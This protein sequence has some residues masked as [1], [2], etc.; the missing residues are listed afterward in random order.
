[1]ITPIEIGLLIFSYLLG[2]VPVGYLLTL[3]TTGKNI[4]ELGSGNVGSTNVGRVAGKKMA[5]LTQLLDMAKG[6]IPVA[7]VLYLKNKQI[8]MDD[9]YFVFG[10]ALAA[11]VGHNFSIFLSGKGGKGVNTTLGASLLIAPYAVFISVGIYFLV[12]WKT[13]YVSIGSLFLALSLPLS[14]LII[15]SVSDRF[16]YL[17]ICSFLILIRHSGNIKRLLKGTENH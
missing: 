1:M 17:L 10:V 15:Y 6:L 11:I 8:I 2:S 5:L 7:L 3:R 12:K 16:Y 9:D 4:M 13:S 14:D